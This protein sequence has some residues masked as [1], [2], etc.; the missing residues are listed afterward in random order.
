MDELVNRVKNIISICWDSLSAKVACNLISVSNEATMQLNL[1]YLLKN[2]LELA[3]YNIDED[4]QIELEVPLNNRICDILILIKKGDNKL[5]LPIEL[6][7]YRKISPKSGKNRGAQDLFK[8]WLYEDLEILE[9]YESQDTLQGI[10]LTITDNK[11]FAYPSIRK[12]K[13]WHYD[14]SNGV[15][16][17]NGIYLDTPIG[18]K[19]RELQL[20]KSYEFNWINKGEFYF[21]KLEGK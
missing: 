16:I 19:P 3:K 5:K 8:F 1:A 11:G 15:K 10:H 18:G 4:I 7:C 14:I 21:L 2:S 12:G 13:G 6:K 20:N 17:D 9:N